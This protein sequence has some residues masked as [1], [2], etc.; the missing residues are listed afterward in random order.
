MA[1]QFTD[2]SRTIIQYTITDYLTGLTLEIVDLRSVR[3]I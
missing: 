2:N 1:Y 3:G